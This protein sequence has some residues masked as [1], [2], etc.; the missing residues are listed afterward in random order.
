VRVVVAHS[1]AGAR[2]R[3]RAVLAEHEVREVADADE[4][5]ACCR[6]WAPDV[7]VVATALCGGDAKTLLGAIKGDPRAFHTAVVL[8]EPHTP[9][10]EAARAA[11][12]CGAHD[13]LV[14]PLQDGEV[15]ARVEAAGSVKGLREEL[16]DQARRLEAL[17][18]EDAL[19]GLA[20]RRSILTQLGG[21]VS[22]AR[23]HGRPLSLAIVD[24]DHFKAINDQHGHDEGDRVLIS[25]AKSLRTHLRAEDQLGRLGGE[26]FL[27]LLGDADAPAALA[28]IEK[29]RVDVSASGGAV[30]ISAGVATWD[31]DEP[32]D[33]LLRRADEALYEAK[34]T[35]R[36]RV[37]AAPPPATLHRRR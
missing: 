28:A 7:A 20:N 35:G 3:L 23:R 5:V 15:V 21:A 30:T 18:F 29:L 34:R 2:E 16:V 22:G 32:A 17:I 31:G 36:D 4:A 9:D 8:I 26:E 10:L 12:H 1:D 27:A 6:E 13:F 24:I 25:V 14:E 37:L 19:T 11:M 33:S